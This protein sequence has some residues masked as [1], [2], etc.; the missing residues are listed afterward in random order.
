[1]RPYSIPGT[2]VREKTFETHVHK[3]YRMGFDTGKVR[4]NPND[5]RS[6]PIRNHVLYTILA[7]DINLV[8]LPQIAKDLRRKHPDRKLS[9]YWI[10]DRIGKSEFAHIVFA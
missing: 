1:M 8:N 10:S 5:K 3:H 6:L 2:V 4:H 9:T 7:K